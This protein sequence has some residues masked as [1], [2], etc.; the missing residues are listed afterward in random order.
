LQQEKL[1]YRLQLARDP[2]L[3][4]IVFSVSDLIDTSYDYPGDLPDGTYYLA[5]QIFDTSG[6]DQLSLDYYID[7]DS[8]VYYYG[9]R[10]VKLGG[11]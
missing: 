3:K 5:L 6:H 11:Q 10:Q 9:V 1:T 4:Q 7:P 8:N 2:Q